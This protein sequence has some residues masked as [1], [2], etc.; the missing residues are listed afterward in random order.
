MR[1]RRAF[2]SLFLYAFIPQALACIYLWA[3]GL[4]SD[5]TFF[6]FMSVFY[7]PVSYSLV[8]LIKDFPSWGAIG[9]YILGFPLIGA[10]LYSLAFAAIVTAVKRR[11]HL[12]PRAVDG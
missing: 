2:W 1:I 12:E 6:N 9:L 3:F 5:T 7:A 10:T 4:G 11:K 8:A